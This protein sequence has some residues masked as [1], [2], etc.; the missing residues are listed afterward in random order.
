[1][2]YVLTEE[3]NEY[4]QYGEYFVHAWIGK[5]T[6]MQLAEHVRPGN[7]IDWILRGGGRID[8]EYHWYNLREVK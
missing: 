6:D 4:D 1:M 2:I 7:N 5:P 3:Y 8:K